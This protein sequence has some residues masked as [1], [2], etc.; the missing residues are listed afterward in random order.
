[1]GQ[2][3]EMT[4]LAL[5][6]LAQAV[7][8]SVEPPALE[9]GATGVVRVIAPRGSQPKVFASA[10][11]VSE[12]REEKPGQYTGVYTPADD[13]LPRV[14]FLWTSSGAW[15]PLPISGAA[16]AKVHAPPRS[17][18]SLTI[19][20]REF[21]PMRADRDGLALVDVVVP[22]GVPEAISGARR[23]PL[24]V[25]PTPTLALIAE[26]G[27]PRADLSQQVR[28]TLY[29]TTPGGA[30]LRDASFRLQ[31]S[32]G[33]LSPIEALE[34]GHYRATWTLS[35][36]KAGTATLTAALA[37]RPK[38]TAQFSLDLHPGP[39][40]T[41]AFESA[42][43]EIVAGQPE[44]SLTATAQ[45]AAGNLT[46]EPPR[47]ESSF[48][49]LEAQPSSPGR[50]KLRLQVPPQFEGRKKV[51]VSSLGASV[52]IPLAPAAANRAHFAPLSPIHAD[53]RSEVRVEVRVDDSFGNPAP[54][55]PP[56]LNADQG[57]LSKV[58]PIE[59]GYTATWQPPFLREP[60]RASLSAA[61]GPL[62]ANTVIELIPQEHLLSLS[63]KAGWSGNFA[64]LH[65]PLFAFEAALRSDRW[66]PMLQLSGEVSWFFSTLSQ[67]ESVAVRSRTDY[68]GAALS[69]GWV[70]NLS[71]RTR[72][73][74]HAGPMLSRVS[75]ALA[76]GTQ[77][78]T[79]GSSLV[80]GAELSLGLERRMFGAI[81]FVEARW[82]LS[83]DPKLTGVVS[84]S[85]RVWMADVGVRFGLL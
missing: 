60:S 3:E 6:I 84:G 36:S 39:A 47:F 7:S 9:P 55:A 22:P 44:V 59:G 63:P 33:S 62:R 85:A 68:V 18:V 72:G 66:G 34:P 54:S 40:A 42:P 30:P 82:M 29:A 48:G 5:A 65:S 16:E 8:L 61:L 73:F 10:G 23:I 31:P 35:P 69:L 13:G 77:P 52:E 80:L 75:S 37:D 74:V 43:R 14:A 27:Q 46:P 28:L 57:A 12:L 32:R 26:G 1:V 76:I 21:G 51:R 56:A 79:Y 15:T 38:L 45:D 17:L 53:G 58:S 4:A 64:D 50:W 41:V 19:G 81:P 70:F 67:N 2:E 71:E 83:G 24:H 49:K 11:S 25:P 20:T 78:K